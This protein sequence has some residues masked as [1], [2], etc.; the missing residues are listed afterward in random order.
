MTVNEQLL[1]MVI[2]A[3]AYGIIAGFIVGLQDIEEDDDDDDFGGGILQPAYV[4]N[5]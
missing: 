2:E 4:T 1:I 5:R 3:I